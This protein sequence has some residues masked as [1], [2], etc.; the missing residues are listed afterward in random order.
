MCVGGRKRSQGT[1][2]GCGGK[3]EVGRA[4]LGMR[5]GVVCWWW[6]VE[7]VDVDDVEDVVDRLGEDGVED[8]ADEHDELDAV[9]ELR[10][11]V[12]VVGCGWSMRWT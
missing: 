8:A 2:V 9:D 11:I 12:V 5:C 1:V 7:D 6:R 10:R 3:G 4:V